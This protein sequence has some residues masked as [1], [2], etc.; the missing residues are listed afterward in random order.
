MAQAP[1]RWI[2]RILALPVFD[3][4]FAQ[5]VASTPFCNVAFISAMEVGS[6]AEFADKALEFARKLDPSIFNLF[7]GR[8]GMLE[9]LWALALSIEKKFFESTSLQL[10]FGLCERGKPI[11]H[12]VDTTAALRKN[13]AITALLHKP[14]SQPKRARVE[15]QASTSTTP[16]LD[17]ETKEKWRWAARLEAIGQRAGSEA[18]LFVGQERNDELSPGE[19]LQLRQLVLVTG[20]YRT[21]AAHIQTFERFE[22]WVSS[23]DMSMYPFCRSTR[24]SNTPSTLTL[25]SVD[26]RCFPRC[27]LRFGGCVHVWRS[28]PRTWMTKGLRRSCQ[29]SWRNVPRL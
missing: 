11:E 2:S 13:A 27:A 3:R 17:K 1:D 8:E 18:K 10:G 24:R 19:R 6:G 14:T 21:M 15:A 16:L 28:S 23:T 5:A 7:Q 4:S 25:S 9:Q 26:R 29:R 22:R 20:S 12:T